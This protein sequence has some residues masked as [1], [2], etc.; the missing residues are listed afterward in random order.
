[1]FDVAFGGGKVWG[2]LLERELSDV[3]SFKGALIRTKALFRRRAQI[4]AFTVTALYF[5]SFTE[6]FH[7][8]TYELAK[9]ANTVLISVE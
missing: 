1:M 6:L 8:F 7:P 9:E 3:F 2:C 4:R 5:P